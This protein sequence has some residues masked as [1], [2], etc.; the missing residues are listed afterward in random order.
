M[1][2]FANLRAWLFNRILEL[3]LLISLVG[4]EYIKIMLNCIIQFVLLLLC[5]FRYRYYLMS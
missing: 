2:A 4:N 1:Q 5:I 3:K